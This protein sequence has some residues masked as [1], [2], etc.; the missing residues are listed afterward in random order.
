MNDML[1]EFL[2][3]D[4]SKAAGPVERWTFCIGLV[5]AGVGMLSGVLFPN[6][7]GLFLV[8]TGLL[9]EISGFAVSLGCMVAR[10][11]NNFRRSRKVYAQ[12]LD[13]DFVLYRSYVAELRKFPERERASRLR[14]IR[15][16]RQVMTY[17]LGLFAGG[18][19]KLGVIPLLIALYLQ[20]KDWQWGD[21][22]AFAQVG[23]VQGLLIWAL[24][25]CY[26]AG[27]HVIGL[28]SRIDAYE[29][30]LAEANQRD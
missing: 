9:I 25:L 1:E 13:H 7:T 28:R 10:E 21:W 30:L 5:G 8:R 12:Q 2:S 29:L 4:L 16:R 3:K 24:F 15:D 19:E 26:A 14:Y 23:L 22:E 6:E 27:W 11:W 18:L 17:R 20:F